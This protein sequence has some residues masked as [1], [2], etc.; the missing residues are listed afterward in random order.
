M[1]IR[2]L[3]RNKYDRTLDVECQN[4][5]C[6]KPVQLGPRDVT[7]LEDATEVIAVCTHCRE[8]FDVNPNDLDGAIWPP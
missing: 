7:A 3:N 8:Q 6:R 2:I 4:G 5:H 1:A